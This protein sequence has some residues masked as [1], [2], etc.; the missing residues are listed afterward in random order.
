MPHE[1][2]NSKPFKA[3]GLERGTATKESVAAKWR[4]LARLH[5]PDRGG[6][7]EDFDKVKKA[8]TECLV[9]VEEGM[10]PVF[11]EHCGGTGNIFKLHGWLK[12][13]MM[14]PECSGSGKL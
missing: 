11:C 10:P 14:C 13:A 2:A 4:E 7:A 6:S 9:L 1:D 5:H 8:Y 3:L 12:V